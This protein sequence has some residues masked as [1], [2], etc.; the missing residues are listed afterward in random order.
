MT[1]NTFCV[2]DKGSILFGAPVAAASNLVQASVRPLLKPPRLH[3][4][5]DHH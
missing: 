1:A 4:D 5:P 3:G 2:P